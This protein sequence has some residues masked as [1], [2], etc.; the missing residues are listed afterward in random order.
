VECLALATMPSA[1]ETQRYV[2]PKP[3]V[4]EV[5]WHQEFVR[6]FDSGDMRAASVAADNLEQALQGINDAQGWYILGNDYNAIHRWKS[7]ISAFNH[8]LTILPNNAYAINGLGISY[9]GLGRNDLALNLFR[10]SAAL[11]DNVAQQNANALL[12]EQ[13][14]A[15]QPSYNMGDKVRAAQEQENLNRCGKYSC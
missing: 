5:H 6:L 7:A 11:G 1:A 10:R 14:G 9:Q 8:S 4:Q 3:T 12:Q 2:A 15:A 13:A